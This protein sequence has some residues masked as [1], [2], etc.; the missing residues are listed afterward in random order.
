M[1]IL[2]API[3]IIKIHHDICSHHAML[4]QKITIRLLGLYTI[5]IITKNVAIAFYKPIWYFGRGIEH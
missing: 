1:T 5:I 3:K 2:R 4:P